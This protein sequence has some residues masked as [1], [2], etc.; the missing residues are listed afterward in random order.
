MASAEK[1]KKRSQRSSHDGIP[2][3]MFMNRAVKKKERTERQNFFKK[4]FHRSNE[5]S[6]G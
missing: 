4:L 2:S 6:G 1:H 3:N 5:R